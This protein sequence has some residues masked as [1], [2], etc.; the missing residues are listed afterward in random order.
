[1]RV[2]VCG[3]RSYAGRATVDVYLKMYVSPDSII[4]QGGAQGADRLAKQWAQS[5][6][7]HCAEVSALWSALGR[8]AGM[9]RNAA[10]LALQ[11]DLCIAFPGG[12]GT[13]NMIKQCEGAGIAVVR[14]P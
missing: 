14:V 6:A 9:R 3:G 11:P 10:M 13:E 1:M 7:V 8:A 4:I 12:S 2:L 5:N